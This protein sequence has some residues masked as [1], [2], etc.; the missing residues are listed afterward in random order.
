MPKSGHLFL[1][2]NEHYCVPLTL[3]LAGHR[4]KAMVNITYHPGPIPGVPNVSCTMDFVSDQTVEGQRFRALL[5][6]YNSKMIHESYP[7]K[8]QLLKDAEVISRWAAKSTASERRCMILERKI[9]VSA[10]SVRK[11]IDDHKLTDNAKELA[12]PCQEYPFTGTNIDRFNCHRLNDHYDF[13]LGTQSTIRIRELANQII[14]SLILCFEYAE[15]HPRAPVTGLLVSSDR[16]MNNRLYRIAINDYVSALRTVGRDVVTQ[17][18]A[19]RHGKNG[20]WRI[21]AN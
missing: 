19:I 20:S 3:P 12:I 21:A 18:T 16:A 7:W 14:H 9:L 13:S 11:L 1:P 6:S 10:F 15:D 4:R 17:I 8:K 5:D 2:K